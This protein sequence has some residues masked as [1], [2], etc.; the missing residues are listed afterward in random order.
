M[1]R[2][3]TEVTRAL[4][5][6]RKQRQ[7]LEQ[8]QKE[9][10][11]REQ[12]LNRRFGQL[13]SRASL[14][15]LT[16]AG[17]IVRQKQI[18]QLQQ[19]SNILQSAKQQLSDIGAKIGSNLVV[20]S[21]IKAGFETSGRGLGLSKR[22]RDIAIQ[23]DVL[24]L[25]G[26]AESSLFRREL[27]EI[28]GLGLTPITKGQTI[29]G[30]EGKGQS[31]EL[32]SFTIEKSPIDIFGRDTSLQA[33]VGRLREKFESVPGISREVE[34]KLNLKHLD[35]PLA[36]RKLI[37]AIDK[38]FNYAGEKTLDLF[39]KL[40]FKESS[41]LIQLGK[42]RVPISIG[43]SLLFVAAS[44]LLA[45]AAVTKKTKT[46]SQL[47]E[48]QLGGKEVAAEKGREFISRIEKLLANKK[49][50]EVRIIFEKIAKGISKLPID[51]R[52]QALYN[53]L[54]L[55]ENLIN[56]GLI[57]PTNLG[58]GRIPPF[59][60]TTLE[61]DIPIR[62]PQTRKT[63]EIISGIKP[64]FSQK[65]KSPLSS[66]LSSSL[67][68]GQKQAQRQKQKQIP[69]FKQA[70][71]QLQRLGQAQKLAQA[72]LQI[73]RLAQP[74]LQ[75]QKFGQPGRSAFKT[76]PK[77][78][79]RIIPKVIPKVP[80]PFSTPETKKK[81][82]PF[83]TIL[84]EQGY[85]AFYKKGRKFFKISQ[86][87]VTKKIALSQGAFI[88]DK[89]LARTFMIKKVKEN[90][91]NPIVR[92]PSG[93]FSSTQRKYRPFKRRKGAKIGLKNTFIEKR[94][95]ALDSRSEVKKIQAAKI[96]AQRKKRFFKRV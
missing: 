42:T 14:Q 58:T 12:L 11:Q 95:F 3:P 77:P 70:Q 52:D 35:V 73:P 81:R 93:Y 20:L 51:K 7:L 75:L 80:P 31:M 29:I 1:P 76:K 57:R 89:S 90:A 21:D 26:L 25:E 62:V 72:Q 46:F 61:I 13:R 10:S 86:V 37:R 96:I 48:E 4:D 33:K 45:T 64:A 19:Q 94:Q 44:P 6:N 38:S 23:R 28:K 88:I 41:G 78:K 69:R 40:G 15:N 79:L 49:Y 43:E 36:E 65:V 39:R 92:V 16:R 67:A 50:D 47:A 9:I 74:T 83:G 91:Q 24:K 68:I 84:N 17:Q 53:L 66:K 34:P 55:R 27:Q 18:S 22:A 2:V 87:P 59:E 30:L 60:T 63:G 82:K 56:K 54:I 8:R 85:K 5:E 71:K 32:P